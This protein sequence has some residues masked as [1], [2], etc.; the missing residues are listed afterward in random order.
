VP[1]PVWL[2]GAKVTGYYAFGPT[3]GAG[4]NATLMSYA[5]VCNVGINIDTSAIDRPDLLMECVREAF[6]EVLAL[7]PTPGPDDEV[8]ELAEFG[9]VA[10]SVS[11]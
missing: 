11:I 9:E 10:E 6:A 3:I 7:A 8:V 4:L 2:A 1:V 5:G